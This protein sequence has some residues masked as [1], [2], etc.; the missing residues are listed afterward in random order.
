MGR[1]HIMNCLHFN[2][3][4]VH[5]A[6]QMA[7]D[8]NRARDRA[9]VSDDYDDVESLKNRAARRRLLNDDDKSKTKGASTAAT[10]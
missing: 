8:A 10:T 4:S 5:S 3:A 9:A 6:E 2:C 7:V 1:N